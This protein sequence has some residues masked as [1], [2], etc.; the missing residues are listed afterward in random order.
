MKENKFTAWVKTHKIELF[1]AGGAVLTTVGAIL[2]VDNWE[3]V[4]GLFQVESEITPT[5]PF[6]VATRVSTVPAVESEPILRIIDVRKHLRNLPKGQHPSVWKI[7]EA[8]ESGIELSENQTI[9]SAHPRCYA[10]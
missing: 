7:Y 9:V 1:I 10:V 8:A 6:N 5:I 2:L 4:K 3:S